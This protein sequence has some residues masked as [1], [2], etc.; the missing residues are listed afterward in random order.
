M[1]SVRRNQ[2]ESARGIPEFLRNVGMA[3]DFESSVARDYVHRLEKRMLV[4]LQR[5]NFV[6]AQ[7]N[8]ERLIQILFKHR[9]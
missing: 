4:L 5:K 8:F 3:E 2:K 7:E 1:R 9:L 6:L